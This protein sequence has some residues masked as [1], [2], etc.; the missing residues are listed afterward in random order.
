MITGSFQKAHQEISPESYNALKKRMLDAAM[1]WS[2]TD[3]PSWFENNNELRAYGDVS[4]WHDSH[5]DSSSSTCWIDFYIAPD[6]FPEAEW[7]AQCEDKPR[8]ID[9]MPCRRSAKM[10]DESKCDKWRYNITY[11]L[12]QPY[13]LH[14]VWILNFS[15]YND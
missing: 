12:D 4:C 6:T 2:G 14:G 11:Y 5:D 3:N 15:T 8:L 1:F 9:N 10:R 13:G 7:G